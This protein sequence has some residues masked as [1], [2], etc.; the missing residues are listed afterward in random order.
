[1]T[2]VDNAFL[3]TFI[4][5]LVN[6]LNGVQSVAQILENTKSIDLEDIEDSSADLY[7]ISNAANRLVNKLRLITNKKRV[8]ASPS[9]SVRALCTEIRPKKEALP[10]SLNVHLDSALSKTHS[11]PEDLFNGLV[12][13]SLYILLHASNDTLLTEQ[14]VSLSYQSQTSTLSFNMTN[15]S[16]ISFLQNLNQIDTQLVATSKFGFELKTLFYACQLY[17]IQTLCDEKKDTVVF[18]LRFRKE[19]HINIS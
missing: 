6:A 19:E 14:K 1:V 7:T 2:Q 16:A 4:H 8:L 12:E 11:I 9:K 5:E 18:Q 15:P 10:N 13:P 3:S 17:G